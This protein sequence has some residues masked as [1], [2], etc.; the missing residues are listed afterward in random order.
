MGCYNFACSIDYQQYITY[1][2]LSERLVVHSGASE[3]ILGSCNV[4]HKTRVWWAE[5][6]GTLCDVP[7]VS[8]NIVPK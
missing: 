4:V 3:A 2:G 6:T 1:T 7:G 5:V 8:R